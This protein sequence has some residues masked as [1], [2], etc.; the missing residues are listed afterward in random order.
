MHLPLGGL[1]ESICSLRS[2]H[3]RPI[4]IAIDETAIIFF[5]ND[6][7]YEEVGITVVLRINVSSPFFSLKTSPEKSHEGDKPKVTYLPL[8]FIF[9]I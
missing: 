3:S 6:K 7:L 4:V 8:R 1:N 2:L 5:I 9:E